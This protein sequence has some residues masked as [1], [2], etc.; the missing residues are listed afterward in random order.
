MIKKKKKDLRCGDSG[1]NQTLRKKSIS[2]DGNDR[3][4]DC[5]F[6]K[7][8]KKTHDCSSAFVVTA[9]IKIQSGAECAN[10]P[11]LLKLIIMS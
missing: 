9:L 8:I 7:N 6:G 1:I 11:L 5:V 4:C 2:I 10:S 3:L